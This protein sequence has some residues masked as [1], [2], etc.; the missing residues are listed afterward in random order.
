MRLVCLG[1]YTQ[2]IPMASG[3]IVP[4]RSKGIACCAL[5]EETGRLELLNI[6]EGVVNP[7]YLAVRGNILCCANELEEAG[8]VPGSTVSAYAVEGTHLRPL[9]RRQAAGPLACHA[10]FSPD[11][12]HV[13]AASYN[14][15]VCV[16]PLGE[17]LEDMSCSLRFQGSG[18]DPD[19]QEGSHP[20]QI[21]LH[22]DGEQ[23][24]VCDLGSDRIRRFR[25]DWRRGWLT[26][27][28]ELRA[29]PGQGPRH[30]AFDASGRRLYVLTELSGEIDVFDAETGTLLQ[31]LSA[32]PE[33]LHGPAMG[34]AVRMHPSGRFL[35]AS[36][37]G[38]GLLA[39]FP[40]RPDGSLANPAFYPSGGKTP[41]DFCITPDG[42]YLL[43]GGQDDCSVCVHAI[44]PETGALRQ[45][46]RMENAGSVT[47]VA[48]L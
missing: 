27:D 8:G 44:D 38:P 3:E 42:R 7:S 24:Y 35:Y 21:L 34:A 11:G 22:P 5:D 47:A 6:T 36:L 40:V 20:H 45:V 13:L 14:G 4:G 46:W 12:R 26:P 48:V 23:V 29:R 43:S 15:G 9:G 39:V 10:A 33:D 18:P 30:G 17:T 31:V 25:A 41:R 1:G 16:L 37:R 2:D 19:R 32:M 28:G